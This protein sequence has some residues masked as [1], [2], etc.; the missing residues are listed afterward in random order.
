MVETWQPVAL[1]KI[2]FSLLRLALFLLLMLEPELE[3]EQV[4]RVVPESVLGPGLAP[5]PEVATKFAFE[6]TK[7]QFVVTSKI[8]RWRLRSRRV[9]SSG[10]P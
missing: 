9:G 5:E 8:V 7:Y 6:S 2:S 1:V 10:C 4:P 3:L